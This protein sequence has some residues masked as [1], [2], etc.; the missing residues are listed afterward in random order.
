MPCRKSC[1]LNA[2]WQWLCEFSERFIFQ[3][4][5]KFIILLFFLPNL[6]CSL[7]GIYICL[8]EEGTEAQKESV[9]YIRSHIESITEIRLWTNFSLLENLLIHFVLTYLLSDFSVLG[10]CYRL[11][12]QWWW[13]QDP[14][15]GDVCALVAAMGCRRSSEETWVS[16][17]LPNTAEFQ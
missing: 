8:S 10:I 13:R 16:F 4:T 5:T 9:L 7:A 15:V 17:L 12:I 2:Y 14:C 6:W 3:V 11:D 1:L